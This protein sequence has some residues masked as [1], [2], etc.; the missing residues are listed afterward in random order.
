MFRLAHISDIHLGPLPKVKRRELFSKRVTGYINFRRNRSAQT[1][2]PIVEN[3]IEYLTQLKP[4]HCAITGDVINLGLDSEIET[5]YNWLSH[6]GDPKD[7][8]L[9]LGNHDAYVKGARTKAL[10]K[11]QRWVCGDDQQPVTNDKDYPVLRRVRN[12]SLICCNSA[13]ASAPFLATG[14]FKPDQASRLKTILSKE[15]SSGQCCVILIHHPPF[16]N[17]TDI[18]KR[19]IGVENF[20]STIADQGADLVIHGHTHLDTINYIDGKDRQIPIICVPAA[21]QWTGY[22]KPASGVNIFEISKQNKQWHID[23]I[24]HRLSAEN[25]QFEEIDRQSVS[26]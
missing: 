18:H 17:A 5:A 24:R 6:L 25:Q 12:I 9:V 4:D 8:S 13:R 26:R 2:K 11:W 7:Y 21:Y 15:K 23:L 16:P 1:Q 14:Y 20:T 3:L 10:K 22:R 19:L